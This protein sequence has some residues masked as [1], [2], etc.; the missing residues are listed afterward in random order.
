MICGVSRSMPV[1]IVTSDEGQELAIQCYAGFPFSIVV[2]AVYIITKHYISDT[3]FRSFLL[4]GSI[5]ALFR[6]NKSFLV[7]YSAVFP[8]SFMAML[9]AGAH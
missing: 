4:W 7:L 5:L 6:G 1:E 2:A 8:S 3:C 9:C